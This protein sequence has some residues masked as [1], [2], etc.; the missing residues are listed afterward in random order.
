MKNYIN[1]IGFSLL[2]MAI[3]LIVFEWTALDIRFQ[4]LLFDP[5][6]HH[7][8]WSGSEPVKRILFYK[9]PKLL[10]IL[11]G[12]ALILGLV[13]KRRF[14]VSDGLARRLRIVLFSMIAIPLSVQ[15]LKAHTNVA[16][17]KNLTLFGGAIAYTTI[18]SPYP[19]GQIPAKRQRGFPAGHASGGFALLSLWFL[20][21]SPKNR[22]KSLLIGLF[23][24][25]SMGVYKMLIGDHF[26]SHTLIS[27]EI[28][29]FWMFTV[30]GCEALVFHL[31]HPEEG[32]ASGSRKSILASI[33]PSK[34]EPQ[35]GEIAR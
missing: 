29:W 9:L 34:S 27:I 16:C 18:F 3:T 11:F 30:A 8:L 26:L 4:N 25:G 31:R 7:W 6:H 24:G 21:D 22:R 35:Q 5:I 12:L 33:P 23:V 15:Q 10:L 28:A 1:Q 20:F 14:G 2:A 19:P 32:H 17:P 13:F